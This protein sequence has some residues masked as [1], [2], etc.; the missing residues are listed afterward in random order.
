MTTEFIHMF[1][2]V[3]QFVKLKIDGQRYVS[4]ILVWITQKSI[5][6]YWLLHTW[7]KNLSYIVSISIDMW[8]WMNIPCD[9]L[10]IDCTRTLSG[11]SVVIVAVVV[12]TVDKT[13]GL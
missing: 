13:F 7:P 2:F 8:V 1:E 3:F 4:L 11:N 5:L 12:V 6:V 10:Q 9:K